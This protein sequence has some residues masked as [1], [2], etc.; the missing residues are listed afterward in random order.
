MQN[1]SVAPNAMTLF[2]GKPLLC[3]TSFKIELNRPYLAKGLLLASQVS[4]LVGPPN[5]GKSS[6][7]AC[8]AAS[9]SMGR[10]IGHIRVKR[11][12]VLYVAAEDPNGIAERSHGYFQTEPT[13]LAHFHIHG[14]PV[15]LADDDEMATF[16]AEAQKFRRSFQAAQM[17]IVFDTLN[18]CIGDGDENSARDMS[19]VI[20]N[21]QRLARATR[22]HVMIIH[23]TSA[24]DAGRPRGSTAMHGNADT[25]LVLRRAEGQQG[26]SLVL[27]TQEKQR[28]IPKGKPLV[29]EIAGLEVGT[30]S[31]GEI[32]TVPIAR[33]SVSSS[34]LLSKARDAR[35]NGSEG[36]A[37]AAEMW[38]VMSA[39]R[40][41]APGQ[42]HDAK[43]LG[44]MAGEVFEAVRA[45]PDSLRKAVRRALDALINDGKVEAGVNGG[46]RAVPVSSPVN[47]PTSG[48]H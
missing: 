23:H 43:D 13:D 24:A 38:N 8:L 31:D 26:E 17:L 48:D 7:V 16:C 22:A 10:T 15:N 5:T 35:S 29:F 25:L 12:A 18:L 14:W 6:V 41:K 3:A 36:E 37:R 20:G 11:G 45:N 19:R 40:E 44:G 34:T 28:S 39:L 9:I 2:L 27:L 21:A 32:I 46:F 4:I 30:D 1:Q 42:F 33:P 47:H